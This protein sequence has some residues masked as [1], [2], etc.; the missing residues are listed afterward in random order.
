MANAQLNA[1]TTQ[2]GLDNAIQTLG[3]N[4]AVAAQLRT[5]LQSRI[6]ED[7]NL[8]EIGLRLEPGIP[9]GYY[10]GQDAIRLG[11]LDPDVMS[12][13]LGHAKNIRKTRMYGN[14]I[15]ITDKLTRANK[16]IAVPAAMAIR[17]LIQD[18]DKRNEILNVLSSISS[19]LAAP[20]L[21]EELMA[22]TDALQHS[23]DKERTARKLMPAFAAH[24]L[25][26]TA[27]AAMYQLGKI[28]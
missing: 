15:R 2:A 12:H 25:S 6:Q 14:L 4:P 10:P 17:S 28:D 26:A 24:V 16:I 11:Q 1:L 27:P 22:T 13:E 19:M 9:G 3:A 23:T 7:P 8:G 5:L 18:P 21:T 20:K